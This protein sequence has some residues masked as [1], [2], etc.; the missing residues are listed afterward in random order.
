MDG[1]RSIRDELRVLPVF[2]VP[3]PSLD[4]GDLPDSPTELFRDW[5]D[6]AIA[7]GIPEPHAMTL[8]TVDP[9]G[10]PDARVLILK[11]QIRESWYFASSAASAKG[12]HL[13][14]D[15]RAAL[16]FYW[17]GIGRQVRIRGLVERRDEAASG[18][19]FLA[20]GLGARAVAL[21]SN[22]SAPLG[23]RSEC[24]AAVSDARERLA[25]DPNLVAAH[26]ALY[27]LTA[28]QVE[29]WQADPNRMHHRIQYSR[30]HGDWVRSLLWP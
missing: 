7:T 26:W 16:T 24:V 5:L 11:D 2:S 12:R 13:Q 15:R 6:T 23:D 29:F 17:P 3:S 19:D 1:T 10:A 25:V 14:D 27:S 30:P 4:Y 9:D 20:R 21:A 28:D 8:S 18:S 22:E